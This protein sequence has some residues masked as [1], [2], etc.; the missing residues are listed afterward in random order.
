MPKV[1]SPRS[2]AGRF[3]RPLTAEEQSKHEGV[4]AL[5]EEL[6][7]AGFAQ[8]AALVI[9]AMLVSPHFLYR[10]ELGA[11][12]E[13]LSGYEAAS[14]LS[15]WLLGTTPSDAL[16]DSA[17]TGELDSVEGLESVARQMLEQGGA[18]EVMRDFHAQAFVLSRFDAVAKPN[19]PEFD[20]TVA[21]ELAAASTL[22]STACSFRAKGC[23]RS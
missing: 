3:R 12:G 2:G 18:V 6:Y 1:L 4:F 23:A 15:F 10:T 8:G 9:R 16:L 20:E 22:F 19:V 14:K 11:A 5:G 7:G 21:A 17:A 13:P